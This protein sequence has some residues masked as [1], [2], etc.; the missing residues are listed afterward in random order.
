MVHDWFVHK[1]SE[2]SFVE[3]PLADGDDWSDSSMKVPL[4]GPGTGA[5]R[6]DAAA[7]L[8]K[9]ERTLVGRIADLWIRSRGRRQAENRRGRQA[10]GRSD[11]AL[12]RQSET[13]VHLSGFTENWWVGLAMLHTVFTREHNYICDLLA[14]EH[15]DWTDAQ[16]HGKAKLIN[17][18]LMAKIHTVEWTPAIL[19]HPVTQIAMHANWYGLAGEELQ[20]VLTFLNDNE[21]L[22]GIVGSKHDHHTA[23][24]ALTEEFVSVYR[25]HPLIPDQV[26]IRSL[27]TDAE[28]E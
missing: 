12:A 23:P 8:C 11:E 13:G 9:S 26:V 20:E 7:G 6:L 25:M 5:G 1:R 10:K 28:V 21:I 3:I 19:P 22:G 14:R 16:L 27:A 17:A 4:I 18:A 24:Y 2:T 15:P